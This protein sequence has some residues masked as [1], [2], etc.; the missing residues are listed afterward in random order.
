MVIEVS[1]YPSIGMMVN[2]WYSWWTRI[3]QFSLFIR[4]MRCALS[5]NANKYHWQ[6]WSKYMLYHYQWRDKDNLVHRIKMLWPRGL[7]WSSTYGKTVDLFWQEMWWFISSW[8][9]IA[10]PIVILITRSQKMILLMQF[11]RGQTLWS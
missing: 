4:K 6:K 8:F 9:N 2:C 7:N 5:V 1:S 11:E 3:I 10:G